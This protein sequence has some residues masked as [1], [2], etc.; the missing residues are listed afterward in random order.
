[1]VVTGQEYLPLATR[2]LQRM[3]LASPAGGIWEAADLQWWSREERATDRDGQLFWRDEH[4][5][6]VAAVILTQFQGSVECDVLVLPENRELETDVWRAAIGR[7]RGL[8]WNAE[9]PVRP[10]SVVGIA[11]LAGAGF[12]PGDEP[13]VISSWLDAG[14]RPRIPE[15]AA[16][17][18]LMSRADEP[19]RPHWLAVRNGKD[20][21]QRLR[22]CS[23]YRP[24]LDLAVAAPDGQTAGYGLFWADP[25]TGV[26]L[27][28]PMRTEQE[29]RR[30]GIA[31]HL[32]ATGLDRLAA[33]GCRRLKVSNDL[34][35]YLRAGFQPLLTATAAVYARSH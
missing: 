16:G 22:Q 19:G 10:E 28:E 14:R 26:G 31:S 15:L 17:F 3:R 34:G 18:C 7:A 29:Y 1:V 21:E 30:L 32:L 9:F 20:V 13:G 33:Q 11:E 25:V 35:I 24:D 27:V 12:A 5:E 23:L 4:G 6:P 2:L 8:G